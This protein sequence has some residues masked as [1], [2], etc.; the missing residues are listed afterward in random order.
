MILLSGIT[1]SAVGVVLTIFF[2]L[3]L[4][5]YGILYWILSRFEGVKDFF[6]QLKETKAA[7]FYLSHVVLYLISILVLYGVLS[8]RYYLTGEGILGMITPSSYH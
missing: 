3:T 6:K 8:L 5:A 1:D 2:T 7:L 4:L